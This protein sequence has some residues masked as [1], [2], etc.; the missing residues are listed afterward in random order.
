MSEHPYPSDTWKV[1][2]IGVVVLGVVAMTIFFVT[3][4]DSRQPRTIYVF[5][6]DTVNL[7]CG[8]AADECAI[9]GVWNIRCTRALENCTIA[10]KLGY[11]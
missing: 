7:I 1:V 2:F 10:A 5:D 9:E 4:S 8:R 3:M 11:E 6:P